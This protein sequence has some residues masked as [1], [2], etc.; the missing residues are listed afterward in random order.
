MKVQRSFLPYQKDF[1]GDTPFNIA[2]ENDRIK[3]DFW[4]SLLTRISGSLS[5][6]DFKKLLQDK[7]K[8]GL[9]YLHYAPS[10]LFSLIWNSDDVTLDVSD[11]KKL[12]SEPGWSGFNILMSALYRNKGGLV[13]CVLNEAKKLFSGEELDE[14]LAFKSKDNE[15]CFHI[16][17]SRSDWKVFENLLNFFKK[18]FD[19][20][21]LKSLLMQK[22]SSGQ[23]IW[24]ILAK[25]YRKEKS[26][27]ESF[28]NFLWGLN[29]F[30]SEEKETLL[31][32][33]QL[34]I[35]NRRLLGSKISGLTVAVSGNF[36]S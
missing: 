18:H 22:D 10:E 32:Q 4:E 1:D 11:R 5:N 20:S 17:A 33:I 25:K 3:K 19:N 2:M 35:C 16:A 13:D 24:L 6:I 29:L 26:F 34:P 28:L 30:T 9:I 21:R 7:N 14:Y 23:V 12:L 15:T 31:F 36:A 27:I 8:V